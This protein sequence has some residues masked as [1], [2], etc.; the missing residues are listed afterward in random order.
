MISSKSMLLLLFC[1]MF[2]KVPSSLFSVCARQL[3]TGGS[4]PSPAQQALFD[5]EARFGAHNYSPLPVALARGQGVKVWDTDGKRYYDFLA[6]YSAVNQG[7]CH[8]RIVKALQEQAEVL[9]L[10]S[11]AFYNN[12]LGEYEEYMTSLFGFDKLLPMNTGIEACETAIKLARKWGYNVKGIPENEAVVLF[13]EENF[14]GRSIA[15]CSSSSDPECY[16]GFGPFTPGFDLVPFDNL[17]ML[18]EKLKNPNVCAFMVEPIQGE[19]G[20]VVPSDGSV[21]LCS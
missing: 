19:A 4:A 6:A 7:H 15:A 13:A 16:T 21:D 14:W 5:R 3:G 12:V 18:E 2:R 20:V 11:R 1:R 9:T 8:P 17:A 10:T